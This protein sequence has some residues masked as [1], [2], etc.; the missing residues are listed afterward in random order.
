MRPQCA[1][2]GI[3]RYLSRIG[4]FATS[5]PEGEP[6][7]IALVDCQPMTGLPLLVKFI[8][9]DEHFCWIASFSERHERLQPS[10]IF[11]VGQ[12]HEQWDVNVL[13]V[14]RQGVWSPI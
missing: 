4:V 3:L 10:Q 5:E 8:G 13:S 1:P 12:L 9:I 7:N 11:G 6:V 2:P 14:I